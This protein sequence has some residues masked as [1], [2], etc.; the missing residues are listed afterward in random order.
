MSQFTLWDKIQLVN[1]FDE[2]VCA[3]FGLLG[4]ESNTLCWNRELKGNFAEI[5]SKIE[6]E[7][8]MIELEEDQLLDLELSEEGDIARKILLSDLELLDAYDA[9]PTLNIIRCYESDESVPFFP[10]D[11]YS[12]HVDRSPIATDTFL[13]TYHGD[14]TEIVPNSQA[15]QKILIPEI[16]SE[17]RKQFGG[18]EA[19]FG[20]YLT[21]NFFDLHYL[22]DVNAQIINCGLGHMWKLAVDHP[23]SAVLPCL[24]RAP[25]EKSGQK[26][27]LLIC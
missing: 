25:Q 14:A 11:V 16:R 13:C 10:T 1:S 27:L 12:F 19:D 24:H 18:A 17:L 23:E 8:N 20:A 7:G 2:L 5:V 22:A 21:E 3:P 26:R 15:T 6:F 4:R 9:A